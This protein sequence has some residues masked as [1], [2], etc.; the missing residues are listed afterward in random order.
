MIAGKRHGAPAAAEHRPRVPTVRHDN[1]QRRHDR[2]HRR[3]PHVLG[4]HNTPTMLALL[5]FTTNACG[6]KPTDLN[7]DPSKARLQRRIPLRRLPPPVHRALGDSFFELLSQQLVQ[8][9]PTKPGRL[10]AAVT[11][12]NAEEVEGRQTP[13]RRA[14]GS[15]PRRVRIERRHGSHRVFHLRP[16]A[17]DGHV[18]VRRAG[19]SE[20]HKGANVIASRAAYSGVSCWRRRGQVRREALYVRQC[21][22][23]SC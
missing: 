13:H 10:R 23:R 15:W 9:R 17:D 20:K 11:V 2:N 1:L 4:R 19:I 14:T 6:A 21:C 22:R 3:R 18:A 12:I 7:I 5:P 8:P 16:P